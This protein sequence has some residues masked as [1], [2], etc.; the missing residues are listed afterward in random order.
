MN[1]GRNLHLMLILIVGLNVIPHTMTIPPWITASVASFLLWSALHLYK[2]WILPPRWLRAILVV[3]GVLGV[4]AE[5][6]TILGAEPASALLVYLAGLKMTESTQYRDAMLVIFTSYFLLMAHLLASQSLPST[7]FM[8]IDVLIITALMFQLH[9]RDRRASMRS[10]K[11]AFKLLL[12]ALPVCVFLFVV[13]PRFSAGF[14]RL[15]PPPAAQTGFSDNLNPGD[16]QQLVQSDETAFRATF[17]PNAALSQD[18]LYWRGA[19][20]H[21]AEGG[22]RWTRQGLVLPPERNLGS[23]NT[24]SDSSSTAPVTAGV[25]FSHEIILEPRFRRWLFGLDVP[26]FIEFDDP[27]RNSQVIRRHG[28]VFETQRDLAVRVLYNVVSNSNPPIQAMSRFER[29][30]YLQVPDDISPQVLELVE[31]L[32]SKSTGTAQSFSRQVLDHFA[33]TGF[34]Y[35]RQPGGLDEEPL[36]QFL[37]ETKQGFCEHYAAAYALLMRLAGFPARVVVGFHGGT[38]N[39]LGGYY[40]IRNL[41]AHAWTEIWNEDRSSWIRVDPTAVVAPMR[42][43]LGGEF[44]LLDPNQLNSNLTPEML[45]SGIH[46]NLVARWMARSMMAFDAASMRWTNFLLRYDFEFQRDLIKRLG[47]SGE[48]RWVFFFWLTAGLI[49]FLLIIHLALRHRAKRED[50]L[51]ASYHRFNEQVEKLGVRRRPQEGPLEYLNRLSAQFPEERP[52]IE[53]LLNE[54]IDLRYGPN[55]LKMAERKRRSRAFAAEAQNL[56]RRLSQKPPSRSAHPS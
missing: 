15:N 49:G 35:T 19:V 50:F 40:L 18:D 55:S 44:N 43:R 14:W 6:G 48:T 33:K 21:V 31:S 39:A 4:F 12:V 1:P 56:T 13:F 30:S 20:L 5:W 52:E 24:R 9:K 22:L 3:T 42:I 37:F 32:K 29:D 47:L 45:R 10:L 2:G 46:R 27:R 41:D 53:A 34:V 25:S 8:V 38:Y 51:L 28:S 54:F 17:P 16:V 36:R 11:P 23:R 26:R 7:I